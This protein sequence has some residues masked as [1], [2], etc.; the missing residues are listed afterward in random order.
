M[1]ITYQHKYDLAKPCVAKLWFGEKYLILKTP[2]IAASARKLID[3]F[4]GKDLPEEGVQAFAA[5]RLRAILKEQGGKG[6]C[7]VEIIL[8]SSKGEELLAKEQALLN[9]KD[10]NC[11]NINQTP[12]RPSWIYELISPVPASVGFFSL[13]GRHR[14]APAIVKLWVGDKFFIWKCLDIQAFPTK[15]NE[16]TERNLQ[17][18]DPD[19]GNIFN[20][21]LKY[22]LDNNI[23]RGMIEVIKK[24]RIEKGKIAGGIKRFLAVEKK[25]LDDHVRRDAACLNKSVNQYRPKWVT[26]IIINPVIKK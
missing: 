13:K 6:K 17:K 4:Q 16:S 11:L 1:K 5:R 18:Y 22:I 3:L 14:A 24:A 23:Q 19:S 15:F 25:L 2:D 8:A 7:K 9:Q 26:E 10:R 21:M 12:D 20:P